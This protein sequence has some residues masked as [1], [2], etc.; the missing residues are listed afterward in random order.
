MR[1]DNQTAVLILQHPREAR[2][3]KGTVRLLERCLARCRVVVGETFESAFLEQLLSAPDR[4][5]V[6]VY[7]SDDVSQSVSPSLEDVGG[8][9]LQLVL[10]DGTWRKSF[11]MLMTHPLLQSLPRWPLQ[12][13]GAGRYGAL[14]KARLPSQLSTLEAACMALKTVEI[15]PQP[16][17]R[18][19]SSFERLVRERVVAKTEIAADA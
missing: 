12:L 13:D 2:E 1:A 6:L 10:L 11:R 15:Q 14:R 3:A 19:L 7:P 17:D 5:S 16:Y 18:V 8:K 9:A 4:R